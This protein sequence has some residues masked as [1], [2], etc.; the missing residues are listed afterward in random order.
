MEGKTETKRT[1]K[2]DKE[3]IIYFGKYK[4][5]NI[6]EVL[7]FDEAYCKWLSRQ[8]WFDKFTDLK[9]VLDDHFKNN[10]SH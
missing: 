8:S 10:I 6:K 2:K 9:S 5:K 1:T 7:T 4:N 3:P